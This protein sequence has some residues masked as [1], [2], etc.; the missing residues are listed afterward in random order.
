MVDFKEQQRNLNQKTLI[1]CPKMGLHRSTPSKFP[2]KDQ[3]LLGTEG[4]LG[5]QNNPFLPYC[6]RNTAKD[7]NFLPISMTQFL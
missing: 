2:R 7:G 4:S 6:I 1:T 5:F 3:N